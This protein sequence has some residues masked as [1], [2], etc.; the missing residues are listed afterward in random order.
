VNSKGKPIKWTNEHTSRVAW[1]K[2][3]KR[4]LKGKI[5]RIQFLNPGEVPIGQMDKE[6]HFWVAWRKDTPQL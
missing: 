2:P 3:G 6:S 4:K 5:R 1:N